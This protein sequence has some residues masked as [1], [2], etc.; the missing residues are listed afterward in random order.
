MIESALTNKLI[1]MVQNADKKAESLGKIERQ[2]SCKE[3]NQI[4]KLYEGARQGSETIESFVESKP[5]QA[6]TNTLEDEK[7]ILSTKSRT[8]KLWVQYLDYI[9]IVKI[10]ILAER[11]GNLHLHLVTMEQMINLFA[12]TGH[13]H[14]AKS[15]RLYLQLMMD[16]QNDFPWLYKEFTNH[17]FNTVLRSERYWSE[18]WTDL[19]IEQVLMRSIKSRGG[20]TRDFLQWVYSVHKTGAVNEDMADFT[21][22]KTYNSEKHAELDKS[23]KTRDYTD[24]CKITDFVY[25]F[26]SRRKCTWL[27]IEI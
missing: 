18:L 17:G 4:Q 1:E 11:T 2:L 21:G 12:G 8:S 26:Y 15:S 9:K 22:L 27:G 14:S 3:A 10:F 16:L 23:R 24:L 5:L 19:V 7:V 13:V 20:L 25:G 6:F